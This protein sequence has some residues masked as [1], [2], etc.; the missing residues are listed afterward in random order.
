MAKA[1][2]DFTGPKVFTNIKEE[3]RFT[4]PHVRFRRIKGKI[5]PII[6]KKRIGQ[7]VERGGITAAKAGIP[8]A[9]LGGAKLTKPGKWMEK[10]ASGLAQKVKKSASY[11]RLKKGWAKKSPTF[12]GRMAKKIAGFTAKTGTK[13]IRH[14]GKIGLGLMLG[15][16]AVKFLGDEIQ[17]RSRF[18]KDYVFIKDPAYDKK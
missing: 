15:G 3:R 2:V 6:S 12:M 11:A 10:K 1:F 14:S 9:A 17:M 5:V 16:T 4:N 7:D 13:T 18:G 8:L